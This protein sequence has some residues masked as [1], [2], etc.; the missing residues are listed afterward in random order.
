MK[1]KLFCYSIF[2]LFFMTSCLDKIN[3]R[4]AVSQI[5]QINR[6]PLLENEPIKL[7][8]VKGSVVKE[9]IG[10]YGGP[11][12]SAKKN[13]VIIG[14]FYIAETEL[15]YSKWYEVYQW[16]TKNGYTFQNLGREGAFGID[17]DIPSGSVKEPVTHISWRDAVVWC[18]AASEK[19]GFIPVYEYEGS[20]LREAENYN[21]WGTEKHNTTNVLAGKGKAENVT[22]NEFATGY[23]LP[24]EAEWEYAARGGNPNSPEWNFEYAG[25]DS[26]SKL[27]DFAVYNVNSRDST[28]VVKSKENGANSL[29]LYDMSGNVW[30]W[31]FDKISL[32][33]DDYVNRGGSYSSGASNCAVSFRSSCR[34]FLHYSIIGFR[35]VRSKPK[36]SSDRELVFTVN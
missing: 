16:A 34:P 29:G 21:D 9:N 10:E 14:T 5:Q 20:V 22:I 33:F 32:G 26:S 25:T 13:P 6:E 24:T 7:I 12:E 8:E 2:C 23:R 18:N 36:S 35:V 19:D 15:T 28:N 11:F 30:E 3:E 1:R 17:G 27:S 4:L 31:C